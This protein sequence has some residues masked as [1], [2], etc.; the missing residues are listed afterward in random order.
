MTKVRELLSFLLLNIADVSIR[1]KRKEIKGDKSSNY[2]S[3]PLVILTILNFQ[4]SP[5]KLYG[6]QQ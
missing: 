5:S 4:S 6:N 2:F 1:F 3:I